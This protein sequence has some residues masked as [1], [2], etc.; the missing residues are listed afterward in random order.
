MPIQHADFISKQRSRQRYWARSMV[1]WQLMD[2]AEPNPAHRAL[3]RLEERQLLA[4]LVTQNVDTL[5]QQAGSNGVIAL[6]GRVD[7]VICLQCHGVFSRADLQSILTRDNPGLHEYAARAL[8]DGDADIDDYDMTSVK[9]PVCDLCGGTLKP[10]V[11]FFGDS[12]PKRRVDQCVASLN[13]SDAL[14]VVGSSLQVYSGY[15]FCQLAAEQGK[16]IYCINLGETRADHL[17]VEKLEADVVDTLPGIVDGL[18][19]GI[20]KDAKKQ[21]C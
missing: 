2:R 16:P 21:R 10:N 19:M 15:R 20:E 17:F 14:L 7:Q 3:A 5:H 11:V 1:G 12:V 4:Q 8:P 9:V 18:L 13:A 6:H